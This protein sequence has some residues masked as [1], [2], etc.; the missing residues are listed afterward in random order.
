MASVAGWTGTVLLHDLA[1]G[2]RLLAFLVF[3]EA[4]HV[5]RRSS[6]GRSEN[7]V[8]NKCASKY[9]GSTVR[10][11]RHHQQ[12]ALSKDAVSFR[13]G[14]RDAPHLSATNIGDSIVGGEAFI[15]ERIVRSEQIQ[16]A[17]VIVE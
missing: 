17:A 9:E 1:Y 5:R 7:I 4:F 2:S 6:R 16:H 3:L 12:S 10:I 11:G 13:I 15:Q 14:Q 8:Q